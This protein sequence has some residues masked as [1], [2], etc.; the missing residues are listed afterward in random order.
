MAQLLQ[1]PP[2][3][4]APCVCCKDPIEGQALHGVGRERRA[5]G[6]LAAAGWRRRQQAA[7]A[8]RA[9]LHVYSLL[10][11]PACPARGLLQSTG[12]SNAA[13]P[14]VPLTLRPKRA[15]RSRTTITLCLL[16]LTSC[17]YCSRAGAA[18]VRGGLRAARRSSA[19]EE[20]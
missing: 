11:V 15:R 14:P 9:Q 13:C 6:L 19:R 4:G 7:A 8:A 20:L 18:S 12:R 17:D 10:R 2:V 1:M 5:C 16:P 3:A